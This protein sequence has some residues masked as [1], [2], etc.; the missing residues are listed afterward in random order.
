MT[1]IQRSHEPGFGVPLIVAR[2]NARLAAL[3]AQA[4]RALF[5]GSDRTAHWR[6]LD[7][8]LLRDIGASPLDAEI[9]RLNAR[10]G[11][12]E[13]DELEPLARHDV[14]ADRFLQ[15]LTRGRYRRGL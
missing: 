9:A 13:T 8:R 12:A 15:G 4:L 3:A 10:M 14:G 7:D 6:S 1:A 11:A 2:F 5:A